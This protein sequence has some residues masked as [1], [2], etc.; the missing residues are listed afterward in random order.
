MSKKRTSPIW[1]K[2]TKE[3][4]NIVKNSY[5]YSEVLRNGYNLPNRAG[6]YY[7]TLRQRLQEESISITHFMK[8]G[9][10]TSKAKKP[11]SEILV[12]NSTYSRNHLKRRILKEGLIENKCYI[13]GCR[14][15]N[16]IDPRWN[17]KKVKMILDHINGISDDHRLA[18][19]RMVCGIC[20][21]QLDTYAGKNITKKKYF[22]KCGY[23]ISKKSKMCGSCSSKKQ[24]K[25]NWPPYEELLNMIEATSTNA[26]SR[27]LGVSFNAV[28]KR[29]KNHMP[30]RAR[31]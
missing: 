7:K 3:L 23:R 2:T 5:S 31:T 10:W 14:L 1:S 26:V 25:I 16:Q 17:G 19:L 29:L 9:E 6:G 21:T 4:K 22:C 15:Y 27:K 11:L 24:E 13:E 8:R 18:N 20:N 28:K 30:S 12:K